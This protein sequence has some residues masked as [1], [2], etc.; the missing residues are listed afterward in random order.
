MQTETKAATEKEIALAI[1]VRNSLN[2]GW[3]ADTAEQLA[4]VLVRYNVTLA[5]IR[6]GLPPQRFR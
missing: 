4:K 5:D 1:I 6:D 2:N 3:L